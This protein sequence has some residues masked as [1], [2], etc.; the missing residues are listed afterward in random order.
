MGYSFTEKKRIRKNFS[1]LPSVIDIP[2]LLAIQ[3]NS[4]KAFLQE[5]IAPADRPRKGLQAAFH[6]IFP[7]KS[8]SGNAALEFVSYKLGTPGFDVKEC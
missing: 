2:N 5:D 8:Y 6:S 1:R 4:Y 7:I 3:T